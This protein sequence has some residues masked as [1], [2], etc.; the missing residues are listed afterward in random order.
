MSN[1]QTQ[2]WHLED[3]DLLIPLPE[4]LLHDVDLEKF[5]N[6][7][8]EGLDSI[9]PVSNPTCA[10]PEILPRDPPMTKLP[11][12][13]HP[14]ALSLQDK[15]PNNPSANP[16]V[17]RPRIITRIIKEAERKLGTQKFQPQSLLITPKS[18]QE[19][20]M[21]QMGQNRIQKTTPRKV[22]APKAKKNCQ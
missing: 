1:H 5:K 7:N 15:S 2:N 11:I 10:N 8:Q 13:I 12:K 9:M 16:N 21:H 22:R 4:N 3:S 20:S 6:V 18:N 17:L 19:K 14:R